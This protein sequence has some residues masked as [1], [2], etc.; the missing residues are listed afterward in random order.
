MKFVRDY[1]AKYTD[2]RHM[3]RSQIP[4]NI[5]LTVIVAA[6]ALAVWPKYRNVDNWP[7]P[8][9]FG[10]VQSALFILMGWF[11]PMSPM[12]YILFALILAVPSL[13]VPFTDGYC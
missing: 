6:V 1:F 5:A 3:I 13:L 12:H 9:W 10:L 7:K 4:Y 11:L 8:F 2:S